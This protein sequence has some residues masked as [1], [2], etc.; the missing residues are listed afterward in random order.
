M[1]PKLETE[2]EPALTS[3][4]L[5]RL[6]QL[7][8]E[9][10]H[11]TPEMVQNIT[12][13]IS[14]HPIADLLEHNWSTLNLILTDSA[15]RLFPFFR[16]DNPMFGNVGMK[17]ENPDFLKVWEQQRMK[18]S[19][20]LK[21][22]FL[23]LAT[24]GPYQ[25]VKQELKDYDVEDLFCILAAKII[26]EREKYRTSGRPWKKGRLPKVMRFTKK[27][28]KRIQKHYKLLSEVETNRRKRERIVDY[29]GTIY[30]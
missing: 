2:K 15:G 29:C 24:H 21:H 22:G 20:N 17:E 10:I 9:G 14:W 23:A 13:E 26:K 3:D 5:T 28:R 19:L 16:V 8:K 4:E 25:Y 1:L 12:T 27:M 30:G 7:A 6:Q 11:L 18:L